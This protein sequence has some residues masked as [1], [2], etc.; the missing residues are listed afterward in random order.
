MRQHSIHCKSMLPCELSNPRKHRPYMTHSQRLTNIPTAT[1]IR[2]LHDTGTALTGA[3]RLASTLLVDPSVCPFFELGC[4]GF[5]SRISFLRLL[6]PAWLE[7]RTDCCYSTAMGCVLD[8]YA[9][10]PFGL[11]CL[12]CCCFPILGMAGCIQ[13]MDRIGRRRVSFTH[14]FV[15][16]VD[17]KCDSRRNLYTHVVVVEPGGLAHS[18]RRTFVGVSYRTD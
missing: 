6:L 3:L 13:S 7:W 1:Q 9:I 16:L 2:G 14:S 12:C 17:R 4:V 10:F 15:R 5:P 18:V 8:F 11:L